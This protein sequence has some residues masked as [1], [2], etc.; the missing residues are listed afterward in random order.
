MEDGVS[1]NET[2][3]GDELSGLLNLEGHSITM[4]VDGVSKIISFDKVYGGEAGY[5]ELAGFSK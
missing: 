3:S 4:T 2:P 1:C 5:G